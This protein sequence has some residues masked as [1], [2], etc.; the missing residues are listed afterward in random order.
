V[1]AKNRLEQLREFLEG[2]L[3]QPGIAKDPRVVAFLELD[4]FAAR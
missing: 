1:F 3:S 4:R 2:F